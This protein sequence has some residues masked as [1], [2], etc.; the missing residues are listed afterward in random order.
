MWKRDTLKFRPGAFHF[1]RPRRQE[2]YER[3][4]SPNAA[5]FSAWV[6]LAAAASVAVTCQHSS[7]GLMDKAPLS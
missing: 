5:A 2:A 6:S 4:G 7:C 3:D 1:C